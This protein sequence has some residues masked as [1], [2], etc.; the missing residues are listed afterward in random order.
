MPLRISVALCTYNGA[1]Y[2]NDQLESIGRQTR[3]VDELVICDDG[4]VDDTVLLVTRF[5]ARAPFP[6]RVI[7]NEHR[8]G[9]A[10]NFEKAIRL[11]TGEL[12]ALCDQDDVW[13]PRK[14]GALCDVL[15]KHPNAAYAFSDG[16]MIDD[17]G[18]P[19]QQKLWDAMGLRKNLHLF[20][21]PGQLRLL[22]RHNIIPGATIA[23]RA[24]F[25]RVILPLP[26]GWMHDYWIVLLGSTFSSGFAV[27]DTLV[28]YR[29]HP[30][31]ACGWRKLSF[32][33]VL[34]GSLQTGEEQCRDKVETFRFLGERIA[35]HLDSF[36][37]PEQALQ[38]LKDKELHL[39][40]RALIR[41]S[42][43]FARIR[44]LLTEAASGRYHR[45]SESWQ[46]I[47]RDAVNVRS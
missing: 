5:A 44:K 41:G 7:T 6:V 46:S 2:L 13:K 1:Q 26:F 38:L 31:Q 19:L 34:K 11:C 32:V 35:F 42:F 20:S 39:S 15:E 8:L 36:Q 24:S 21:G 43:G 9:P 3:P 33:Q 12:I 16:D 17:R 29:R 14:I 4:S 10:R 30:D 40:A 28:S 18:R 37:C 27:D 23:F 25:R 45:F 47:A 22:L